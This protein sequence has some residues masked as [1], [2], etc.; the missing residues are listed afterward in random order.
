MKFFAALDFANFEIFKIL[1]L[2]C[3]KKW[4][5]KITLFEKAITLN[6]VSWRKPVYKEIFRFKSSDEIAISKCQEFNISAESRMLGNMDS[7][8][9]N[10]SQKYQV[11]R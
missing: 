9:I 10:V 8:K 1:K 7:P 3:W 11:V 4:V 2:K 6:R 5:V